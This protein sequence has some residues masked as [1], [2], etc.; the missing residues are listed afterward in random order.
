MKASKT[1][2]R[3]KLQLKASCPKNDDLLI[4]F[5]SNERKFIPRL[6]TDLANKIFILDKECLVPLKASLEELHQTLKFYLLDKEILLKKYTLK[7]QIKSSCKLNLVLIINL[8]ILQKPL[9]TL[10]TLP[11]VRNL[12]K[13]NLRNPYLSPHQSF[14]KEEL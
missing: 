6:Q 7:K 5:K 12:L 8:K 9:K 4:L 14:L 10:L 3:I 13:Q 11:N 2:I 1:I